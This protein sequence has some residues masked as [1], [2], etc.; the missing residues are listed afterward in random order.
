VFNQGSAT[1]INVTL[2]DNSVVYLGGGFYND[3]TADMTNTTLSGNSADLGG[4]LFNNGGTVTLTNATLSDNSATT[5]GGIYNLLKSYPVILKNTIIADSPTGGNCGGDSLTS[6]DSDKY[7]LS[8]DNTCALAG[9]GSRNG[10]DPLLSALGNYGGQTQVHMPQLGSPAIDAVVGNDAPIFD[11][12]DLPRP[13]GL[14]YDIGAVERQPSDADLP[15][16]LYLP[17]ILR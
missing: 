4:G 8:S 15:P 5:G 9:T 6:D 17:V 14:G 10:V 1:L 16:S 11:Q 2:D 7:S 12:R 13:Q 3:G